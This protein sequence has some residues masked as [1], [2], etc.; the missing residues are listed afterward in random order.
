MSTSTQELF[1]ST[2]AVERRFYSRVAPRAPVYLAVDDNDSLLL[3][4]SENGLL[5]SS[6]IALQCNFVARI[7]I[8]LPGLPKPVQVNVRVVW[9]NEARNLAGIQLLDLNDYDREQIRK[10]S[11][12]ESTQF[13][14][15]DLELEE[16]L[17]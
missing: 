15:R 3:N 13:L 10:W 14:H 9:S 11:T 6:P 17:E 2:E 4:V 8:P 7:D 16:G 1:D 12:R 5:V